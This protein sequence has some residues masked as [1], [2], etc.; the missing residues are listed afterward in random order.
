MSWSGLLRGLNT[1]LGYGKRRG[2]VRVI[3]AGTRAPVPQP[4]GVNLESGM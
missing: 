3:P 2:W 1:S 4:E